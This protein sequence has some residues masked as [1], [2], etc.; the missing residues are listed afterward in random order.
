MSTN[1]DK[2]R[3]LFYSTDE[4]N[5][6]LA[7]ELA[8][9]ANCYEEILAE[10]YTALQ[11]LPTFELEKEE[12]LEI[13]QEIYEEEELIW[14]T[15]ELELK[16]LHIEGFCFSC[17]QEEMY[18]KGS[19]A[20]DQ[21]DQKLQTFPMVLLNCTF[22]QSLDLSWNDLEYLPTEIE[23]L[24]KLVKLDLSCNDRLKN[25]PAS[26][27]NLKSLEELKLYGIHSVLETAVPPEEAALG[28]P[29]RY[30]L[31][32]FFRQMPQLKDLDL[33]DVYIERLPTWIH[34]MR[35]LESLMIFSG[36]GSNP[37]LELPSTFTQLSNLELLQINAYTTA[38]PTDIDKM[39]SLECLI[40]E[41]AV[42]IPSSIKQLKKLHYLDLSYLS[43]DIEFDQVAGYNN[44]FDVS[45]KGVPEGLSRI[46]IYGWEWL[47]EM[48]Q[49]KEF[50][51]KHIEPYAFTAVE[52]EEL[53]AALPNCKLVLED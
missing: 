34:E 40:V 27:A 45:D 39:Q 8:K 7:F 23:Q 38:I 22:I 43:Y 14:P 49:L 9:G 20:I 30:E 33:G 26:L 11:D 44:L 15:E 17:F 13:M 3:K 51:F 24:T 42:Q 36:S 28:E 41:P 18:L 46:K 37:T 50:T 1:K 10:F 29:F 35:G 5:R 16:R 2:I 52:R 4:M 47:K 31:P 53:Q 32:D 6:K 25:L 12:W 21:E 19:M 48:T